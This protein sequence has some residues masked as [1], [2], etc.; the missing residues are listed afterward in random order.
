MKDANLVR[1]GHA[2]LVMIATVPLLGLQLPTVEAVETPSQPQKRPSVE[3]DEINQIRENLLPPNQSDWA[4]YNHGVEGWRY[5][6][7]ESVLSTDNASQLIEKWRFPSADSKRQVGAIHATPS[8]VNGYV[9]FGT[10]TL[11]A[12]YKL[13]PDGTLAW[14]YRL[15]EST[16]DDAP[17]GGVNRIKANQGVI[18]SAL[19][20]RKAVYFGNSAGVFFALDRVTG[21]LLWRVDTRA[22]GFPN[23]HPINTFCASAILADGKVVVG[24]GGYEHAH[25][26]DPEYPCCTG[27]GF[28]VAF[29]P[30][31]GRVV[32]KYEVGEAPQQ[33]LE[34]IVVQDGNGEHVFTHGPSTSSVWS[35]PSYDKATETIYFGTDVHNSP[36]QPTD[37]DPR[38][39][40]K[41]SAAVIAVDARTGTEKWVTQLNEGDI[42][43]HTMSGYDPVSRRYKDCSIGDTPK[44][45]TIDVDGKPISVVGVGC[46]NGGFYV[47]RADR[48]QVI[49]HTPV[50]DGEPQYPLTPARDPRTIALPSPIG[51]IQTGCATDGHHV[52]TNGIDWLSLN[53]K[54]PR[55]P[56]AGRVVC[57]SRDLKHELWRHERPRIRG[58][59]S[60]SGDPVAAG[61]ALGGGLACFAPT[62]SERL[63]VLNAQSGAV[64]KE[65]PIGVVWSGPSISRGRIY[66]GTGSVLF[67]KQQRT[68]ALISFGLPGADEI[69]RMGSGNE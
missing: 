69:D 54:Q 11:P 34:P 52:Y 32:W 2:W 41:Y 14:V 37:D 27:R 50:Y 26:L 19:V 30:D 15:D 5:N 65:L 61:V 40:T 33:F 10:A 60:T 42:Y 36:R 25:P 28:V 47:L 48:G 56:E 58:F 24:G 13:K 8:V 46:K 62:V 22:V 66:V 57:I 23:H 3:T 9:Y 67:L 53:T 68:G 51:G 31:N 16:S 59:L 35:T 55:P 4:T 29:D 39:Y 7:S 49:A 17:D 43:N 12:F 6:S 64:L 21:Q 20:T 63:V 44:L 1:L 45:Y 38:L 18:T